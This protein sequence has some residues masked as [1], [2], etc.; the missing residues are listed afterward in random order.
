[1]LFASSGDSKTESTLYYR[2]H[3]IEGTNRQ[4]WRLEMPSGES[5]TCISPHCLVK[6]IIDSSHCIESFLCC[7][8][9]V[10]G[11]RQS[12]YHSGH[13]NSIVSTKVYASCHLRKL[14][15]LRH[16]RR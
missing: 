14:E 6:T 1:M 11:I 12:I 7:G 16:G 10:K 15:K 5:I 2:P 9:H 4:D 13:P 3:E 8:V